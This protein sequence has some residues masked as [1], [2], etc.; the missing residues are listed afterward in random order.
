MVGSRAS[1]PGLR[2]LPP[3]SDNLR[4]WLHA[5]SINPEIITRVSIR[6]DD[7]NTEWVQL[8]LTNVQTPSLDAKL[9]AYRLN[10]IQ[11]E[12]FE[13]IELRHSWETLPQELLHIMRFCYYFDF[14]IIFGLFI[15]IFGFVIFRFCY[16]SIVIIFRFCYYSILFDFVIIYYYGD[17]VIISMLL[18]FLIISGCGRFCYYSILLLF[19]CCYYFDYFRLWSVLLLFRFCYHF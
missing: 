17:F 2:R 18:F 19:R 4:R 11:D 9:R 12:V 10:S 16:Y 15:I 6:K 1:L 13:E 3:H 7:T 5:N 8:H 14:V